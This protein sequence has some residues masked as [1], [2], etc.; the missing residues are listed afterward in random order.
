MHSSRRTAARLFA[1]RLQPDS[2]ETYH[3]HYN[4][5]NALIQQDRPEEAIRHYEA[6]LRLQPD[7]A[8]AHNN[9]TLLP[10]AIPWSSCRPG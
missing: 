7:Y 5:A 8:K 3:V 1:L 9:P 2:D 10:R 6:A 4:L